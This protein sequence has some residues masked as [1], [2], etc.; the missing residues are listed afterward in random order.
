MVDGGVVAYPVHH[1]L[2]KRSQNMREMEFTVKAQV[3]KLKEGENAEDVQPISQTTEE[4]QKV[5]QAE[6]VE[7]PSSQNARE[8]ESEGAGKDEL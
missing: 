1:S 2:P 7:K 8:T 6:G 5:E 3:L 4:S